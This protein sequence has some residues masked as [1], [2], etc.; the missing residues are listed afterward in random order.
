MLLGFAQ[1]SNKRR[2]IFGPEEK[3]VDDAIKKR[4]MNRLTVSSI[5]I[6]QKTRRE[7]L[8]YYYYVDNDTRL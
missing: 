5:W 3:R 8:N 7:I 1:I 2:S 6:K 4:I